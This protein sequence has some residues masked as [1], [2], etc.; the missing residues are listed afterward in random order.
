MCDLLQDVF[1]TGREKTSAILINM[2]VARSAIF[3]K[4]AIFNHEFNNEKIAQT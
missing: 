2:H 4:I 3:E 1:I